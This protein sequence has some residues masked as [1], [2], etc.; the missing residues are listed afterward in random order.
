ML[1]LITRYRTAAKRIIPT[2]DRRKAD[3]DLDCNVR[4]FGAPSLWFLAEACERNER[5]RSA[6]IVEEPY[7]CAAIDVC[8]KKLAIQSKIESCDLCNIHSRVRA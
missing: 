8:K 2:T 1:R 3:L 6:R 4:S 7:S 5:R